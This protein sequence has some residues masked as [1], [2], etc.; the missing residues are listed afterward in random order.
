MVVFN[1]ITKINRHEFTD[2]NSFHKICITEAWL[3][4]RDYCTNYQ[5]KNKLNFRS[6]QIFDCRLLGYNSLICCISADKFLCFHGTYWSQ[7]LECWISNL[8]AISF[9]SWFN[10]P[11]IT[12]EKQHD[13]IAFTSHLKLL[14]F[15][16]YLST[17]C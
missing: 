8:A 14:F 6:V 10:M 17:S 16:G 5:T 11:K 9:D 13:D 2:N 15:F 1:K 4:N 12:C 3:W 7:L